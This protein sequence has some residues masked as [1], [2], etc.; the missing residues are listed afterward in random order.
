M[1]KAPLNQTVTKKSS[2]VNSIGCFLFACEYIERQ[3]SLFAV[4]LINNML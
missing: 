2:N 3:M 4:F 1:V